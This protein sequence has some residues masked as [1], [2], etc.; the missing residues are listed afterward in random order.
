M[1][2]RHFRRKRKTKRRFKRRTTQGG[3]TSVYN[4][5][6]PAPLGKTFKMTLPYSEPTVSLDASAGL[7]ADFIFSANGLFD[8]SVT[9]VGHQPLGYDQIKNMYDHWVVIASTISCT[10]IN[11]SAETMVCGISLKDNAVVLTDDRQTIENGS[12]KYAVLGPI[13][14]S[15]DSKTIR[16]QV[17]PNKFLGRSHPLSDPQ[18]K[19]DADANPTEQAYF[20][21]WAGD[22]TGNNPTAIQASCYLEYTAVFIEPVGLTLS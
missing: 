1:A 16:L 11:T 15:S 21:V 3:A 14:S 18:V 22:V 2:R 6:S 19:G 17:N 9:G 5:P 7:L 13:G 10:F 12:G 4:N 20:H 8:P